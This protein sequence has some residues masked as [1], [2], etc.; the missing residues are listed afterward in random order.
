VEEKLNTIH[1]LKNLKLVPTA[2]P[3]AANGLQR[4]ASVKLGD[5]ATIEE[6]NEQ[7]EF[8]RYNLKPSLSM[9]VTKKQDANT[10]EVADQV[11]KVLNSY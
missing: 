6:V 5:I 4:V 3:M 9:A 7:S 10:I 11:I 2:V 1:E 8:T